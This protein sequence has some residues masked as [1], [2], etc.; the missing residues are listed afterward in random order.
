MGW[1]GGVFH[2]EGS[3]DYFADDGAEVT[4][5]MDGVETEG[6]LEVSLV[7]SLITFDF[8]FGLEKGRGLYGIRSFV[9]LF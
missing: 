3:Q 4:D 7:E 1:C 8:T 9:E 2:A 5:E 6:E